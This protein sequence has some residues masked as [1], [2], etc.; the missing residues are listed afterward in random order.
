M[1]PV[2]T[3]KAVSFQDEVS[4]SDNFSMRC[5]GLSDGEFSPR[6]RSVLQELKERGYQSSSY[7]ITSSK[8]IWPSLTKPGLAGSL[9][10]ASFGT[11]LEYLEGK[12]AEDRIVED[13]S[14]LASRTLQA[15]PRRTHP[16][17]NRRYNAE[18]FQRALNDEFPRRNDFTAEQLVGCSFYELQSGYRVITD[19]TGN[20]IAQTLEAE[21]WRGGPFKESVPEMTKEDVRDHLILL[22]SIPLFRGG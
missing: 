5:S 2:I 19:R 3:K 14:R 20:I 1:N 8:G 18:D 7:Q 9:E 10:Q 13:T 11:L 15:Y 12:L 4:F 22:N 21:D 6:V 17:R 16:G